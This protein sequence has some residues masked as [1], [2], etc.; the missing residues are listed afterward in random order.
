MKRLAAIMMTVSMMAA[1]LTGC[2][3]SE[4]NLSSID[5]EKYVT[6]LGEYKGLELSAAKTEVTDEY[7]ESYIDYMLMNYPELV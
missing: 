4:D 5:L 6:S 3:A 7:I 2:G 1:A